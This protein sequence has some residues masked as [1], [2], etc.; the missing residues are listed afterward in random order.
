MTDVVLD[1]SALPLR[2]RAPVVDQYWREMAAAR[3]EEVYPQML[4]RWGSEQALYETTAFLKHEHPAF[5]VIVTPRFVR[6][7]AREGR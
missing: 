4:E 7:V 3:I 1:L 5:S 2:R 6:S